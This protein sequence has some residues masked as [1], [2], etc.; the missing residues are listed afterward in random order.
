MNGLVLSRD[1]S[2]VASNAGIKQIIA[3]GMLQ[4]DTPA[5]R[6]HLQAFPQVSYIEKPIMRKR[7]YDTLLNRVLNL[8]IDDQEQSMAAREISA[9][10]S[11][12]KVLLIESHRVDQMVIS[13]MLKKMGFYV[14]LAGSA[15]EATEI[16]EKE[17]FNLV[18]LDCDAEL[19]ESLAAVQRI[20]ADERANHVVKPLPIIA[21][22]GGNLD[23]NYVHHLDGMDDQL[24]KPVRYEDLAACLQR[25]T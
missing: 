2:N 15:S 25:W 13:A 9:M 6:A 7:L 21:I 17:K 16:L 12:S 23:D 8:A 24:I 18:L 14:Q 19:H 5:A 10:V 4:S 11:Q 22:S 20:R 3:L 1:I